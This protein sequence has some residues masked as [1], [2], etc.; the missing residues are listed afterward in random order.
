MDA[1]IEIMVSLCPVYTGGLHRPQG[2][3]RSTTSDKEMA[4]ALSVTDRQ[5]A[6]W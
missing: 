2:W 6:W 1:I 3:Y 4:S 5:P